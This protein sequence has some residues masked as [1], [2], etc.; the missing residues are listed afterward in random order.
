MSWLDSDAVVFN[1]QLVDLRLRAGFSFIRKP[2]VDIWWDFEAFRSIQRVFHK[3]SYSREN[4]SRRIREA[5]DVPVPVEEVS[6]TDF[7][8]SRLSQLSLPQQ[9]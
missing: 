2:N 5:S 4:G 1:P 9:F 3:F 8:E 6:R 7:F